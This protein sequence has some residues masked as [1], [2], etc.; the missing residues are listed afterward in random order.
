VT[1]ESPH[2]ATHEKLAESLKSGLAEA[3]K[4]ID[5]LKFE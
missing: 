5:D 1:A 2:E 4:G 3:L